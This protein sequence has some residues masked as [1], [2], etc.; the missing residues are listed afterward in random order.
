MP[1]KDL[2]SESSKLGRGL[3]YATERQASRSNPNRADSTELVQTRRLAC[4]TLAG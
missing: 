4:P 3:I 1:G 2:S